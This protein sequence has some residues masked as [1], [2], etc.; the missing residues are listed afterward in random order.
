MDYVKMYENKQNVT[1]S[2]YEVVDGVQTLQFRKQYKFNTNVK[3]Y[4]DSKT[5]NNEINMIDHQYDSYSY[6]K[7]SIFQD[8]SH[9]RIYHK[10][11]YSTMSDIKQFFIYNILG[12]SILCS[13]EH[14]DNECIFVEA[15]Q[16]MSGPYMIVFTDQNNKYTFGKFIAK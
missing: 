14:V 8:E 7:N 15:K 13:I 10:K 1:I 12:E 2:K 9:I 6:D 11:N 16:L 3:L 4:D 5:L